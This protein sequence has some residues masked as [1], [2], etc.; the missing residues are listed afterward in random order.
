M[1]VVAVLGYPDGV[2]VAD[3]L[4][5]AAAT[6]RLR[7]FDFSWD[8]DEPVHVLVGHDRRAVSV[9]LVLRH[10]SK[11]GAAVPHGAVGGRGAAFAADERVLEDPAAGARP[12]PGR[13]W[14]TC[15][16]SSTR[17]RCSSTRSR[18]N[19]CRPVLRHPPTRRCRR[20]S[21]RRSKR[22][23]AAAASLAAA[24][25]RTIR[26][27][28]SAAQTAM[29][30]SDAALQSVRTK[31]ATLV[32]ET[33][34][35]RNFSDVNH[36]IPTF[37]LTQ[38]PIGLVGLLIIAIIMAATDTIAGE[39]NSLSTATVIDFYRRWVRPTGHRQALP[40]SLEDRD[41][42]LGPFRLRRGGLGRATW[43]AHRGRQPVRVVFLRIDSRASSS[44]RSGSAA[45]RAPARSWA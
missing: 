7:T 25:R 36:I 3:G 35:D 34:G 39:L 13:R 21:M 4:G 28:C 31:A 20:S 33:S 26:R 11:P 19:A 6:G 40:D 23:A 24:R 16:T 27:S 43:I 1:I 22:G 18:R 5:I 42:P 12:R 14:C 45:R 44:W 38:L 29:R 2:G 8:L 9:L 17:R 41:G 32:R 10:R 15:S 37:I 30:Q